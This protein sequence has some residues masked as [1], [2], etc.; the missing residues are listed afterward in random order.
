MQTIMTYVPQPFGIRRSVAVYLLSAVLW[1]M[2]CGSSPWP[3]FSILITLY[4]LLAF[5]L[6]GRVIPAGIA[7]I[8]CTATAWLHMRLYRQLTLCEGVP[9]K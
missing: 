8:G 3:W 6:T 2:R 5:L 1:T 4:G 7:A 9:T